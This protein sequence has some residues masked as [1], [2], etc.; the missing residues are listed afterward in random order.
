LRIAFLTN[1]FVIEYMT[2]GGL[3]NYLSRITQALKSIGHEPEV[4]VRR[5]GSEIP[6]VVDYNGIR[7]EHV[8]AA[9]NLPLRLL[10]RFDK[11]YLHSPFG[12]PA[13]YIGTA[14]GLARA[15][16]R[17][18]K[19][20]PFDFVQSTN[21]GASGL[22]VRNAQK[23][24]HIIRL[25]SHRGLWFQADGQRGL[26][27]K[28]ISWLERKCLRRADIA[29]APSRFV[30]K[31][32]RQ[33]GW[34]KD[35]HVVRPPM[36]EETDAA[37]EVPAGLPS[38]YLIHFG[39]I[40]PRKGSDVLARALCHV[41]QQEPDFKM[42][43]A[44]RVVRPGDY[45]H[46]HLMWGEHAPN[47]IWMG[48]VRKELLYAI[49]KNS[50]A[51]VLPSRADNLPNTVIESLML[52]VPVIGSNG[53]SIDELVQSG[54]NGELVP[55]GDDARLAD[56]MIKVWRGELEWDATN[57]CPSSVFSELDPG[58]A[59]KNLINLAYQGVK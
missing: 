8:A 58:T 31:H 50:L 35:V 2:S 30:A 22:F 1:E 57:L 5:L 12:G 36:L 52:G 13:N 6:D 43:W 55:V 4:F 59:V 42:I 26:G 54:I 51:A 39:Q 20:R 9:N 25:S 32:C 29:Y 44:G 40:G 56:A 3:G 46:C 7:V 17:R 15:L 24:P 27:V 28:S 48:A 18:H 38:R 33:S 16:E 45:E 34:R 49:L 11:Q 23:R 21:C 53:A 14:L 19:E 10:A 47:V 41:W 37:D